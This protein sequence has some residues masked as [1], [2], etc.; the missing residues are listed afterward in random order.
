MML[1]IIYN[2]SLML[3]TTTS[4]IYVAIIFFIYTRIRVLTQR[5]SRTTF[6]LIPTWHIY[7]G[8]KYTYSIKLY[9]QKTLPRYSIRIIVHWRNN[10]QFQYSGQSIYKKTAPITFKSRLSESKLAL[11]RI[12]WLNRLIIPKHCW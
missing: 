9:P 10:P 2:D 3:L 12:G 11:N 5:C 1:L 6:V 4:S 8:A 7:I